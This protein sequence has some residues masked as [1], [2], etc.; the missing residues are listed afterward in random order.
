MSLRDSLN[1]LILLPF[2]LLLLGSCTVFRSKP[3]KKYFHGFLYTINGDTVEARIKVKPSYK[4]L[5]KY[6]PDGQ[7]KKQSISINQ[8]KGLQINL[9]Q[10]GKIKVDN[11][12]LILEK[13]AYGTYNLYAFNQAHKDRIR[14][15]Y[16]F[17]YQKGDVVQLTSK[18]YLMIL[19]EY[20]TGVPEIEEAI[21]NEEVAFDQIINTV[22]RYNQKSIKN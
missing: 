14:T 15:Y 2:F 20:L 6:K 16:Y 3:S 1:K 12:P 11:K 4:T 10:Y 18:N 8:L 22:R 5:V 9:I 17:E 19:E 7:K 13:V 21:Y